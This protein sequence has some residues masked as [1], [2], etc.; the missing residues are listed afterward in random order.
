MKGKGGHVS[1]KKKDEG[2]LFPPYKKKQKRA[3]G[4]NTGASYT[5]GE[6]LN[7]KELRRGNLA[8]RANPG[9]G[10]LITHTTRRKEKAQR[11]PRRE[12]ETAH[13]KSP[14][15]GMVKAFFVRKFWGSF[16]SP[17]LTR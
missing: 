15:G 9:E 5:G 6:N 17:I 13:L 16:H 3:L 8:S 11:T 12:I 14:K 1:G 7:R 4:S 2:E 10:K